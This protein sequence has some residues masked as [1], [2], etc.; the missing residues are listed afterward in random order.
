MDHTLSVFASGSAP[1][2][3]AASRRRI[4]LWLLV[5]CSLVF[6]M[7]VV[8]GVTRLT[9]SGLSI[10]EWQPIAGTL[11]PLNEAEWEQMF[12]KY[13][14]TPEYLKVNQGMSLPEFKGIFWWEYI[15]RL[16][17]R[18]IGIVFIVPLLWFLARRRVEKAMIPRLLAIFCL[19]GLQGAIGWWMVS[20][21]LIDTP[22]V[23]HVR[24]AIHLGMAFLIFAAM[25]WTALGL[26]TPDGGRFRPAAD[27]ARLARLAG[28]L[29]AA[30]FV[31]VLSGALVAGTRAGYAYNTFP[32]M[33]GHVVP[34]GLGAME[35]WW[36]N[37]FHNITT[38]Q[39]DHRLIAWGLFVAIP[40]FWW[41]ARKADLPASARRPLNLLL[42]MLFVQLGL[43]ISTLLMH[44]PVAL[45]A[46]HQ[47]GALVLF[48][49]ALWTA[50]ALRHG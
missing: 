47:G 40:L 33:D 37:L 42:A 34:P 3:S 31:M 9:R 30:V 10:V 46:A 20:S 6:V 29:S 50:H 25:W 43:G 14:Q 5:C 17:G 48:A 15:H 36:D 44:V 39:F 28:W 21:G 13:R 49:L 1:A 11:P 45:G 41:R 19:G 8:G 18:A 12:A 4:A 2:R 22:R 23:S 38:V 35:P 26:L 7:V 16:L 24:L 27:Q 32:L